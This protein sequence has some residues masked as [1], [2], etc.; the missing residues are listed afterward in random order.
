MVVLSRPNTAKFLSISSSLYLV[1]LAPVINIFMSGL[2]FRKV[3][4][5]YANPGTD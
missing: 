2:A 5:V 4:K 3:S 1:L